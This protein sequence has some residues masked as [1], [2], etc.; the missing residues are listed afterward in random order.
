[1]SDLLPLAEETLPALRTVSTATITT[2]LTRHGLRR[3][4]V[5][6][7]RPCAPGDRLVGEAFTLRYIPA[8]EDLDWTGTIDNLA[9]AQRVAIERVPPGQVLVMDARGDISS[10]SLGAILATRLQFRGVA[11]VVTDGA[12]RDHAEI[13]ALQMPVFCRAA[14]PGANKIIYHP[15]DF[16]LP[17]GC[18]GVAVFPGDVIVGDDD[19][20]VVVPRHLANQV[21]VDGVEMERMERFIVERIRAGRSIVGTYPLD[22]EGLAEYE[23]WKSGR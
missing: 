23:R 13:G 19:G 12:V 9:D 11:G 5:A 17:I 18:G 2:L 6:G 3:A 8:R 1:M 22:A 15:Q 20:A 16:G 10:G 21:A 4:V 7:V 14:H